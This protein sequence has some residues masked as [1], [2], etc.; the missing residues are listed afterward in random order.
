MVLADM[1]R[2]KRLREKQKREQEALA[3]GRT[4]GRAELHA[5]WRDWNDRRIEPEGKNLS[6]NEPPPSLEE[7]Q[8]GSSV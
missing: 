2:E 1:S 8:N 4:E 5:Q 6:F 3:M 7:P